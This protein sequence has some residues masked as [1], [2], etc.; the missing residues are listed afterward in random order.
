MLLAPC[1]SASS[2][3]INTSTE[4][5]CRNLE[6]LHHCSDHIETDPTSLD[7]KFHLNKV[8]I[9]F[10]EFWASL[11]SMKWSCRRQTK[12]NNTGNTSHPPQFCKYLPS[13]MHEDE[14]HCPRH[15]RKHNLLIVKKIIFFWRY[16][17]FQFKLDNITT[18]K[19]FTVVKASEEEEMN[20]LGAKGK[21]KNKLMLA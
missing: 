1:T 6:L 9:F 19:N 4:R 11:A 3:K 17:N 14:V 8:W 2:F 20:K 18:S 10:D 21:G 13:C 12:K 15:I 16:H 5:Q 7:F